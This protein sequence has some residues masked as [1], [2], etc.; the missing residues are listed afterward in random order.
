M[1][2]PSS[3]DHMQSLMHRVRAMF[4][5]AAL[6]LAAA[7]RM[8][9]AQFT[10]YAVTSTPNG[11]QLVRF[12]PNSPNSVVTVGATGVNL[13]GIDFRPTINVLYGYDGRVLYTVDINTGIATQVMGVGTPAVNGDVGFDFNPMV[14]R[15]RLVGGDN[16][17]YRL[18][19]N[20]GGVT[21]DPGYFFQTGDANS[22]PAA[23]TAV[24]Y[25]NST[26]GTVASTTLYAIDAARGILILVSNPNG[27]PVMTLGSLGLGTMLGTVSFDIVT[28]DGANTAFLSRTGPAAAVTQLYTVNLTNGATTFVGNVGNNLG[29]SGLAITAVPEPGTWALL[30]VGLVGVG[31]VARRRAVRR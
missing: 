28:L 6:L 19:P 26:A 27:G 17:N 11:Q 21:T 2:R 9:H 18:N 15:I 20:G 13:T 4:A 3:L 1:T 24:A 22:G 10:A 29:V 8:A 16:L 30:A 23:I 14:D 7:P 5:F 31:I 25:T 12:D